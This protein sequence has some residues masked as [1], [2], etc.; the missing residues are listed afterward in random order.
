MKFLEENLL[1]HLRREEFAG[2]YAALT[3]K[4]FEKGSFICDP[5]GGADEVFIVAHGR[6][7]AYLGYEDK[8]F[9]LGILSEGDIFS[10]HTRAFIQALED[11]EVLTADTMTFHRGMLKDPEITKAMV[12]VLGNMLKA[13]F[14]IIESLAFRSVA[15]RVVAFLSNE[16][17]RHGTPDGSGGV[18]LRLDL[19]VE[20]IAL[21]VGSTRQTVSSLLNALAREGLVSRLDRGR[22]LV[23]D[24]GA[25]K[26]Y[27]GE[28]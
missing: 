14:S 5:S 4:R 1:D 16:A 2:L 27:R 11:T 12:G 3:M 9:T 19:P 25:L 6:A 21:M 23:P 15:E 22:F 10:S 7:R 24:P 28:A 8:E 26:A 17:E 13:S 20:Q 18:I